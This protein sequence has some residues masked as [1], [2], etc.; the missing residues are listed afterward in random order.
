MYRNDEDGSDSDTVEY[1][2]VEPASPREIAVSEETDTLTADEHERLK[3]IFSR[4][5]K[6]IQEMQQ[7]VVPACHHFIDN[8]HKFASTETGLIST[9]NTFGKYS[10]L[11]RA[12]QQ[13]S[14]AVSNNKWRG[15][16]IGVQPIAIGR[17]AN[18]ATDQLQQP[19]DATATHP[20]DV[21]PLAG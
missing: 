7:I 4:I 17:D 9:L 21:H 10:G 3:N 15:V 1:N 16:Q 11:P 14:W 18:F 2:S 12:N 8:T 5:R 20:D 13:R 6:G 19:G